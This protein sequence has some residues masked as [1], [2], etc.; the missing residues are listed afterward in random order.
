MNDEKLFELEKNVLHQAK[1]DL[2]NPRFENDELMPSYKILTANYRKLLKLTQKIFS[3]SDKQG[4]ILYQHQQQIQNLLDH[5]DQGFLTFGR[6]LR[7]D[8]LCSV[9]CLRI[10]GR[11]IGG[12]SIAA[13]LGDGDVVLERRV[14]E[15]LERIFAD[16][17]AVR[18]ESLWVLPTFYQIRGKNIRAESK[19]IR[20]ME[21]Q[22]EVTVIMLILTDIT[23]QLSAKEQ[24]SRL[25]FI[26]CHDTLTSLYNRAQLTTIGPE[27][28]SP[29]SLPVSVMMVDMNGLKMVNDVFGHQQGDVMLIEMAKT[30]QKICRPRDSIL[31]WGGDEF[32]VFMSRTDEAEGRAVCDRIREACDQNTQCVMPLSAAIGIVTQTEGRFCL[33]RQM[34][35]AETRMYSHKLIER[36]SV[37]R[38]ILAKLEEQLKRRGIKAEEHEARLQALLLR[39]AAFLDGTL[40][41]DELR[42]LNKLA[43]LHNF[44]KIAFVENLSDGDASLAL[45]ADVKEQS[46]VGYRMAQALGEREVADMVLTLYERWDGKGCPFG[47]QGEEIPFP[48][49]V[50]S[51]VDAYDEW[52]HDRDARSVLTKE[53]ALQAIEKE[54]GLYFDPE[55]TEKFLNFMREN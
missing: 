51:I 17:D 2:L 53:E 12:V 34:K 6:S 4:E 11:K 52:M 23:A 8:R 16:A 25:S 15:A 39:F 42:I 14:M 50:F 3:I 37:R 5:A 31:R 43:Y 28:E 47:L 54:K 26:S 1:E 13:L 10:F 20:Q 29:D 44:G 9:E 38:Q 49:R 33:E 48:A 36:K 22:R 30:L 18:E 55:L 19:V 45:K 7:V 41:E 46:E 24:I 40:S 32:V 27:L 35:A 21:N